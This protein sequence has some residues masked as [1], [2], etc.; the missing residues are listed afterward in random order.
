MVRLKWQFVSF[1]IFC[2]LPT[3][4]LV[5]GMPKF[6]RRLIAIL[7]LPGLFVDANLAAAWSSPSSVQSANAISSYHG[8]TEALTLALEYVRPFQPKS[9]AKL[10]KSAGLLLAG[11]IALLYANPKGFAYGSF[12]TLMSVFSS[13]G[14][15]RLFKGVPS[16]DSPIT[17]LLFHPDVKVIMDA[18][19]GINVPNERAAWG[20]RLRTFLPVP[21]ITAL[22]GAASPVSA[23][24]FAHEAD[25]SEPAALLL[26]W[27]GF[28]SLSISAVSG[29]TLATLYYY[30]RRKWSEGDAWA[31]SAA[32]TATQLMLIPI[33]FAVAGLTFLGLSHLGALLVLQL[34]LGAKASARES[35][36][37]STMT[38][39][40]LLKQAA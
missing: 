21:V 18:E 29:M 6:I 17:S 37:L 30:S 32:R 10:Y 39:A 7:L 3:I 19:A 25:L 31:A 16:A 11:G 34:L 8:Q 20:V 13:P 35:P 5:L 12:L 27:A 40:S 2:G 9:A 36:E 26:R 24:S 23:Q 1:R 38:P 15:P 22:I 14:H 33:V 28:W 4:R